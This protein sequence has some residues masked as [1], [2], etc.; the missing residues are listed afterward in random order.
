MSGQHYFLATNDQNFR[1]ETLNGG[2]MGRRL[3]AV[4]PQIP[5]AKTFG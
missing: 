4:A 1:K 2:Q 3:A 5:A